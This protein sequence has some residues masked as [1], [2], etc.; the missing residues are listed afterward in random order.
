[1]SNKL[2][3][4]DNIIPWDKHEQVIDFMRQIYPMQDELDDQ[5]L[6]N[7]AS[8]IFPEYKFPAWQKNIDEYNSS[9]YPSDTSLVDITPDAVNNYYSEI[10]NL[11]ASMQDKYKDLTNK[12]RDAS[13]LVP[14]TEEQK[15]IKESLQEQKISPADFSYDVKR[16]MEENSG[17]TFNLF[18]P[19][20]A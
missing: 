12:R 13:G 1:M 18:E 5:S 15:A 17:E 9:N 8:E 11:D 20:V 6:W 14:M 19:L 7:K 3:F 16:F 2:E 4:K 10:E